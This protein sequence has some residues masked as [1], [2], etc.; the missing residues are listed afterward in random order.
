MIREIYPDDWHLASCTLCRLSLEDC[1]CLLCENCDI[2]IDLT[3]MEGSE[4]GRFCC[5][6][7][8]VDDEEK[9]R[10]AQMEDAREF[11]IWGDDFDS[12]YR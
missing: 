1:R 10:V 8:V 2:K 11:A 5:D 4:C 7:C 6:Q 9:R 12:W 3:W